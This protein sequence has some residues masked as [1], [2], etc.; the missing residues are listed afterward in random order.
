MMELKKK[1]YSH[2]KKGLTVPKNRMSLFDDE[3]KPEKLIRKH[4]ENTELISC[5][6]NQ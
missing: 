6:K 1:I 3:A 4:F 2:R 5:S